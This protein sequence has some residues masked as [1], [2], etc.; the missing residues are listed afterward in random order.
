MLPLGASYYCRELT[1]GRISIFASLPQRSSHEGADFF[2][3][4][5]INILLPD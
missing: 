1:T 3:Q 4:K 2:W 5:A